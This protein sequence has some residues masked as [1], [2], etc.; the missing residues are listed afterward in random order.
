MLLMALLAHR[1]SCAASATSPSLSLQ[2]FTE[3]HSQTKKKASL[4]RLLETSQGLDGAR[5]GGANMQNQAHLKT[6]SSFCG[7]TVP[8]FKFFSFFFFLAGLAD[9]WAT[10]EVV[11]SPSGR[12]CGAVP[13]C[14]REMKREWKEIQSNI[15]S[16][17]RF[18]FVAS[19][20]MFAVSC[21]QEDTLNI[22]TDNVKVFMTGGFIFNCSCVA[23]FIYIQTCQQNTCKCRASWEDSARPL[24]APPPRPPQVQSANCAQI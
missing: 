17:P 3:V 15:R 24:A 7:P 12:Y 14:V 1:W 16:S 21:A 20:Q 5:I 18:P 19:K 4:A 22:D 11:A 6:K 9:G 10:G 13:N 8:W 2:Q 23:V